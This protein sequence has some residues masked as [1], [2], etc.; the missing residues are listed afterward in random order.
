[1]RWVYYGVAD[2]ATGLAC[3]S[4]SFVFGAW[5]GAPSGPRVVAVPRAVP[6]GRLPV[7]PV[8]RPADE[9]RRMLFADLRAGRAVCDSGGFYAR[10]AG[11][12]TVRV[13]VDGRP[14]PCP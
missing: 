4:W 14:V 6:P 5:T 9:T 10:Q 11:A 3:L 12:Q 8:I 7:P 2:V 1:M 13:L